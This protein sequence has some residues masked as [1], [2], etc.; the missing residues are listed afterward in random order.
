M[1]RSLA[2][3]LFTDRTVPIER[4]HSRLLDLSGDEAAA[5][6]TLVEGLDRILGRR[7]IDVPKDTL[8]L[9]EGEDLAGLFIVVEGTIALSRPAG[10]AEVLHHTDSTGPIV[11][12]SAL[13]AGTRA[14]FTCRASTDA[15]VIPVSFDELD[16][17]LGDPA[18]AGAIVTVLVRSLSRR[19]Q[20]STELAHHV[21][22]LNQSL[23]DERDQLVEALEAL[24]AAQR[25]LVETA[26]MATLGELAAGVAHELNNPVAAMSRAAE[27]IVDDVAALVARIGHQARIGG[28]DVGAH[29]QRARHSVSP[30]TATL[31]DLRRQ[32]AESHGSALA[33]ALVDA[34]ITDETE[35]A[36][37][38]ALAEPERDAAIETLTLAWSLGTWIRNLASAADRIAAQVASL[39]NYARP[40]VAPVDGVNLLEQLDDTLRLYESRLAG[41]TIERS[42]DELP[43][44]TGW[45]AALHQVWS[46]LVANAADALDG[47]GH[48]I[49]AADQPEPGWV[50]VRI[51]D[52]GPGIPAELLDRI[53]EPRF[54][55]KAGRVEFGLGIGLNLARQA[56]NRH[57]GTLTIDSEPGRTC[58]TVTLPARSR[59]STL[60]GRGER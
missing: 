37:I 41:V 18:M 10:D 20:R 5:V 8:L 55:T 54:T 39:R 57:G 56:V 51:I 9:A 42:W 30:G 14:Q 31:R 58:A 27:R 24:D 36:S 19:Q 32:L 40:D 49:V 33:G 22:V 6:A 47:A 23:A 25:T 26:R 21:E 43:P 35:A 59:A 46:N 11:G 48:L 34:G 53:F 16:Q 15:V 17:L 2:A 7:R 13:L 38:V 1:T 45:P 28:I 29:L 52:D 44:I 50:R 60:R 3:R 4:P 12:L